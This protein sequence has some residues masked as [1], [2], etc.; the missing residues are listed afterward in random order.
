[1]LPTPKRRIPLPNKII[2]FPVI[3][4]RRRRRWLWLAGFFTAGV[5]TSAEWFGIKHISDW[6]RRALF[7]ILLTFGGGIAEYAVS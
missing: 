6:G 7:L 3:R 5:I 2:E 4:T 1:M